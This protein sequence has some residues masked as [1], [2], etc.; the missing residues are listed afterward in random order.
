LGHLIAEA[1]RGELVVLTDGD[2]QVAL[3]PRPALDLEQDSPELEAELLRAVKGPHPTFEEDELR[4]LANKTLAE[5]RAR[6]KK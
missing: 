4:E 1:C 3:E 6:L 5:H 2:K